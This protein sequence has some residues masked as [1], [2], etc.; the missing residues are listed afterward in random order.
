MDIL[1]KEYRNRIS[2]VVKYTI[3][4]LSITVLGVITP[5]KAIF[6]GLAVG[7]I[8][9]LLNFIVTVRKVNQIGDLAANKDK[10]DSKPVFSGMTTRF[11]LVIIAAMVAFRFPEY[12]N[13]FSMLLGLFIT[14][15]IVVLDSLKHNH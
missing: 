5:Y 11:S 7:T 14:Q 6:I 10:A 12:I 15:I 4:F 3:Y 9:G 8:V 13:I 2:R 1:M